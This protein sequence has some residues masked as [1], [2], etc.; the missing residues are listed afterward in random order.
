MRPGTVLEDDVKVGNFVEI[1]NST[2][3]KGSKANHLTY[4]GDAS[5][6]TNSNIGAGTITCNYDGKNKFKTTIGDNVFVGS[7]ST[8]IAPITLEDSACIGAGSTLSKDVKSKSLA[9]AR[10]KTIVKSGWVK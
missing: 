3:G 4:I 1:K 2:I 8:L 5:V 9:V 7:N 6:G 10:P